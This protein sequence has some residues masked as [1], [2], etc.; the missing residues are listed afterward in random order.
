MWLFSEFKDTITYFFCN[1][2]L[3]GK[4]ADLCRNFLNLPEY[5]ENRIIFYIIIVGF[6]LHLIKFSQQLQNSAKNF[7]LPHI[8]DK[9][10]T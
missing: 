4:K 3:L 2:F 1:M 7:R 9:L 5:C 8:K 6:S 10:S